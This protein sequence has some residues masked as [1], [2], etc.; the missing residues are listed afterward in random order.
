MG[1]AGDQPH[2]STNEDE[3]D[4]ND[5][6]HPHHAQEEDRN[7]VEAGLA[8]GVVRSV[9]R[10][11]MRLP[12]VGRLPVSSTAAPRMPRMTSFPK[13]SAPPGVRM[14]KISS[15][16]GPKFPSAAPPRGGVMPRKLPVKD[17]ARL[18]DRVSLGV[19]VYGSASEQQAGVVP[20]WKL[21]RLRNFATS[22]QRVFHQAILC[23]L[24]LYIVR[25]V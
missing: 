23:D 7:A 20:K 5:Q 10:K 15:I 19:D 25:L 4:A 3:E 9:A 14:P 24:A 6:P 17:V 12:V 16:K 2:S 22:K 8:R 21:Q 18:S 11:G 13:A 1:E